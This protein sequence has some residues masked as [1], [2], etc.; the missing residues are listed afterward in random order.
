M[1]YTARQF[2]IQSI[3]KIGGAGV[4]D[5]QY[6]HNAENGLV[7]GMLADPTFTHLFLTEMDM[8]LPH[9]C[10]TKLLALDKDIA[11]GLYFLRSET[12]LDTGQPCVYKRS[13][14]AGIEGRS[15]YLITQLKLFPLNEPFR[16]DAAGLGC[17]LIKREVFE[18]LQYPWFDLKAYR[19]NAEGLREDGYGSDVYFYKHVADA[20]FEVWLDPT[21][22]C[23]QIDYYVAEIG[24]YLW[25]MKNTP[26][27]AGNG[28]FIIGTDPN[29]FEPGRGAKASS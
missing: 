14:W 12:G 16:I 2:S 11:T 9:D 7:K 5:R 28:G 29:L 20:G 18:R 13:I 17:A 8:V 15:E 26:G 21:V 3:G 1:G 6:T 24:D 25:H 27:F 19:N 4:T 10:I 22:R 23:Q